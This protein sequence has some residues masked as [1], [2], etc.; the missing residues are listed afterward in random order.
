MKIAV[1]S[2]W[3]CTDENYPAYGQTC[4]VKEV[5]EHPDFNGDG[6]I[7]VEYQDKTTVDMKVRRFCM[8][9]EILN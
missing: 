9:H 4:V 8:R 7:E 2:I 5:F 3:K 1:G 6:E